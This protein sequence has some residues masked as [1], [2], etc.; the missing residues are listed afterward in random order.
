MQP[1]K[2]ILKN[3]ALMQLYLLKQRKWREFV[4]FSKQYGQTE[5][6]ELDKLIRTELDTI[7][8]AD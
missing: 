1:S 5:L 4:E 7:S 6:P 2:L 3:V 8:K